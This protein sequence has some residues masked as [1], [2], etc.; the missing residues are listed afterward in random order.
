MF[1]LTVEASAACLDAIATRRPGATWQERS[2][3]R[4]VGQQDNAIMPKQTKT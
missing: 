2:Q 4:S 3:D 1:P